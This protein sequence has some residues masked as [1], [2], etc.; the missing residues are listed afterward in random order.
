LAVAFGV[1]AAFFGGVEIEELDEVVAALEAGAVAAL[2]GG[3]E[4]DDFAAGEVGPEVDVAGNEGDFLVEFDGVG[5]SVLAENLGRARGGAEDAK[6]DADGGGFAGA[7]GPEIGEN[8]ALVE[9]EI[10]AV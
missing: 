9:S 10:D 2:E 5:P 4:V 7:V 1:G 8:F 3:E 6:Q